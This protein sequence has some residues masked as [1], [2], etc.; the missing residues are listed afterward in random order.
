MNLLDW[1]LLGC[2]VVGG[3][4]AGYMLGQTRDLIAELDAQHDVV[5]EATREY[6]EAHAE[7]D[8][9]ITRATTV[10]QALGQTDIQHILEGNDQ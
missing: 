6:I 10:A 9:R 2:A 7:M 4:A 5:A 3:G 8:D 1:W